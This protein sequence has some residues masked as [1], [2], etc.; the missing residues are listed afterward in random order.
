MRQIKIISYPD[1]INVED[2]FNIWVEKEEPYIL[3]I[4]LST[5][6]YESEL[7]YTLLIVYDDLSD[8]YAIEH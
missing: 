3:D 4:N 2:A 6:K 7:W 8:G 5:T 1:R